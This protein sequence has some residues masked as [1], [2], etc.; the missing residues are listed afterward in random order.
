MAI[1]YYH[2]VPIG[3]GGVSVIR[4]TNAE[5]L[6]NKQALDNSDLFIDIIDEEALEFFKKKKNAEEVAK[7]IQEK[8]K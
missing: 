7:A 3:G 2:G 5:Y 4:I 8:V 6:A 1:Q